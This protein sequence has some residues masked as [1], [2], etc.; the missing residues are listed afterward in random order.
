MRKEKT[1]SEKILIYLVIPP[2]VSLALIACYFCGYERIQHLISP[3]LN[4]EYG[5]LE[6]LQVLTLLVIV[7]LAAY[8]FLRKTERAEK[9]IMG[10][11]LLIA[12]FVF[13]EE[14][15]Y[16]LHYFRLLRGNPL[17]ERLGSEYFNVHNIGEATSR[18]KNVGDL[19][20]IIIFIFFPLAFARSR[21]ALLRYL[22]PDRLF[23][24]TMV[25]MFA[26]SKF[27]H[28]LKEAGVGDPGSLHQCISEF[29]E[30]T[31]YYIFMVYIYN[32]IFEKKL[33]EDREK[34]SENPIH[35]NE[36]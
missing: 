21:I 32:L 13:L 3:P 33:R 19:G 5:L 10:I 8:G 35:P 20:M 36:P 27:A 22:A 2:A 23:I 29:R 28:W 30:L 16:G 31:I 9:V 12:A 15:D 25:I 1:K 7:L 17:D 18:F 26:V 6:N 11:V 14:L 4:R 24:G 34:N